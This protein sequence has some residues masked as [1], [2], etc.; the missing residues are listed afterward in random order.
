MED[1]LNTL[2]KNPLKETLEKLELSY[3]SLEDD[4][5]E[6]FLDVACVPKGKQVELAIRLLES[7]G[8]H[9]RNGLKVLEQKSL[10]FRFNW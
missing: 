3:I 7:C 2:K 9:A 6:I 8:F 4:Y 10:I 1:A 5:K